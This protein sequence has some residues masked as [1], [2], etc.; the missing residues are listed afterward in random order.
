MGA[1]KAV[2]TYQPNSFGLFDMAGNVS[3]WCW[4]ATGETP[5]A[6]AGASAPLGLGRLRIHRGGGW[7]ATIESCRVHRL[8]ASAP[9]STGNQLGFRIV[10][11][12]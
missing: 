9:N 12:P 1:T 2:K 3:E 5:A 4:N 10:R 8:E 6:P 11:K 7:N